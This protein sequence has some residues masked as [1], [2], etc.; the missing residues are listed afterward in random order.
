LSGTGDKG[1]GARFRALAVFV[2][3]YSVI[4]YWLI[5]MAHRLS[6]AFIQTLIPLSLTLATMVIKQIVSV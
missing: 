1:Q 2:I 3:G 6:F 5:G 4:S